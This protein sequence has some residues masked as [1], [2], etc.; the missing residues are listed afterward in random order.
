LCFEVRRTP[1]GPRQLTLSG[2]ARGDRAEIVER[3]LAASWGQP[4][5]PKGSVARAGCSWAR[6]HGTRNE[7]HDVGIPSLAC[8][9]FIPNSTVPRA[10][11]ASHGPGQDTTVGG[12]LTCA[13]RK[14]SAHA[15]IIPQ[16]LVVYCAATLGIL[17][18]R[19]C[20]STR[21]PAG[22]ETTACAAS[23]ERALAACADPRL[24]WRPLLVG[25]I[26]VALRSGAAAQAAFNAAAS[27]IA[28][29]CWAEKITNGNTAHHRVYAETRFRFP[30]GSQLACCARAKAME[31]LKTARSNGSPTCPTFGPRGSIRYD[32][33]TYRLMPLNT[34]AGRVVCRMV[35]GHRQHTMLV[36]PAWTIGG[37]DL[38]WRDGTY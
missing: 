32:A 17:A 23:G 6:M 15:L 3:I 29:V 20:F 22:C 7:E 10:T 8:G 31:A 16:W 19:W 9:V 14:S 24:H 35:L 4:R 12:L 38:V 13:A 27:W 34:L 25:W 21:P 30:L 1:A 33:R 26:L 37:A 18:P 2:G 28:S 11:R 5:A 36:D